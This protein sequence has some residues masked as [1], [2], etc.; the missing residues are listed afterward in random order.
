M[1]IGNTEFKKGIFLAPMAGITDYAFRS[2]C[3]MYGVESVCSE[4]ISAK[5]VVY[6]DIKTERLAY[7]Y[8]DERPAAIQLFGSNPLIMA[9]AAEKLL[10]YKPAYIDINMG[11]PVPKLVTNREGCALMRDPKLCGEIVKE[12]SN[13]INVPVTVKIRKGFDE[14]NVNAVEI[15]KISEQNGAAAVFVHGRT[16]SQMYSGKADWSIIKDVKESVS[17]PVIGNGDVVDGKTAKDMLEQTGCDGIMIGRGAYGNPWIFTE[18]S[19][20]L[21]GKPYSPPDNKQKKM[22]I[23]LQFERL[24]NNKGIH[25]LVEARKH[26]SRYVKGMYGSAAVRDKINSVRTQEEINEILEQMFE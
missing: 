7:L 3:I 17:I 23:K 11:C 21:D 12:V 16:R 25:A 24:E 15:A 9:Q 26:L 22:I 10:K 5:A 8:E 18:I 4:L 2:I 19:A 13:A 6:N 1:K 20:F 14:Q